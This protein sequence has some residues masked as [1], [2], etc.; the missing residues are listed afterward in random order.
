MALSSLRRPVTVLALLTLLLPLA[1]V[2]AADSAPE[3][4]GFEA[5]DAARLETLW[6]EFVAGVPAWSSCLV[7]APPL[8]VS[9]PAMRPRAAYSP[10]EAT[11]FVKPGD[12]DR[13]VVIHELAHHLDFTCG[14]ADAVGSDLRA[15]QGLPA[16]RAWWLEGAPVDWPAEY[17]ANAVVVLFG[18]ETRHDVKAGTV[19][20]VAAWVAAEPA[21]TPPVLSGVVPSLV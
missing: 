21:R 2:A 10:S 6:E 12:L 9:Q 11:L 7:A 14:A 8:I 19:E 4:R 15:A 20:V 3:I 5:P 17:F 18:E 1:G 13:V 16:G